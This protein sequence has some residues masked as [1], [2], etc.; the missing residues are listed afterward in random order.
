MDNSH[1]VWCWFTWLGL[2]AC[3]CPWG[4][5]ASA[6]GGTPPNHATC[7]NFN[8]NRVVRTI[9][10][11]FLLIFTSWFMTHRE[12]CDTFFLHQST[13]PPSHTAH[14]HF[15]SGTERTQNGTSGQKWLGWD[16]CGRG[17]DGVECHIHMWKV[18]ELEVVRAMRRSLPIDSTQAIRKRTRA[19]MGHCQADPENYNCEARVRAILVCEIS[20][21]QQK[22]STS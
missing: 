1:V 7:S 13:C 3:H 17:E 8:P 21:A 16:W 18:T 11:C 14:N 9:L 19:G 15:Q 2:F 4:C 6:G 22:V 5:Q 10:F 12:V 20:C